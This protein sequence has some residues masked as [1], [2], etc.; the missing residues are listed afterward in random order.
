MATASVKDHHAEKGECRPDHQGQLLEAESEKGNI[1][2]YGSY[3][4]RP[5]GRN[6][7][8]NPNCRA[9]RLI[10]VSQPYGAPRSMLCRIAAAAS[11][12]GS[13]V[14]R[15]Q[16]RGC[17]TGGSASN[18]LPRGFTHFRA[19]REPCAAQPVSVGDFE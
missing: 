14:P 19:K 16:F 11:V 6:V 13:L 4:G 18:S 10:H 3:R 2:F 1:Y 9:A 7:D 15:F 5:R 8:S 12:C 17:F